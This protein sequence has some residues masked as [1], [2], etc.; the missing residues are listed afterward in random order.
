MS[1][2]TGM[3]GKNDGEAIGRREEE[4][5]GQEFERAGVEACGRES[6]SQ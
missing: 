2:C 5:G 6:Q 1:E 3:A 4:G